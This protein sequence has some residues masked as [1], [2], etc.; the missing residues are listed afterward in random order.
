LTGDETRYQIGVFATLAVL[1]FTARRG[2][3]EELIVSWVGQ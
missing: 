3:A 1:A 2:A